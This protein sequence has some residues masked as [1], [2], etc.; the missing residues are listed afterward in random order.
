MIVFDLFS[1]I[2]GFGLAAKIANEILGKEFFKTIAFCEIDP[3]CRAVI[4]KHW[5]EVYQFEDVKNVTAES[6]RARG[7]Q[8][9]DLIVGGFPCQ[10]HSVAGNKKGAEDA[11]NLWPEFARIIGELRPAYILAENV[12]NL[13]NTMLDT[14]RDDLIKLGYEFGCYCL[15]AADMGATHRR[16]RLW[17]MANSNGMRELQPSRRFCDL[18]RWNRNESSELAYTSSTER[19]TRQDSF[20]PRSETDTFNKELANSGGQRLQKSRDGRVSNKQAYAGYTNGFLSFPPGLNDYRGWSAVAEMDAS[21][22]PCVEREVRNMVDG[23]P[24]GL[25]RR[26]R[27]TRT[28]SSIRNATV[29]ALGNSIVPACAVP[30]LLT[31]AKEAE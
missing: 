22:M 12:P 10:P 17:I 25:V 20:R 3:F 30:F 11:R 7:L 4:K 1:G 29:K 23:L 8:F 15:S 19:R 28:D 13:A 18:W 24:S 16:E 5:P 6:F 31:I 27:K 26:R 21:L 2:A 9:P 14:V